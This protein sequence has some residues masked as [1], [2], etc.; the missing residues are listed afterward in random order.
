MDT[1]LCCISYLHEC[2]HKSN[3]LICPVF[4]PPDYCPVRCGSR[5]GIY[6][7]IPHRSSRKNSSEKFVPDQREPVTT[8]NE[9]DIGFDRIWP[10]PHYDGVH[11]VSAVRKSES[12]HHTLV[13]RGIFGHGSRKSANASSNHVYQQFLDIDLYKSVE[14]QLWT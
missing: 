12:S 6:L 7:N 10:L 5:I 13:F 8:N 2:K 4:C 14:Q 1:T 3:L 9:E 11:D